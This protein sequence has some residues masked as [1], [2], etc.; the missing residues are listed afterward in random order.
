MNY[1]VGWDKQA[2]DF[3]QKIE[4]QDAQRIIKKVTS[5]TDNPKRY[6]KGLSNIDAHKLRVGNYRIL[7]DISDTEQLIN[8]LFIGHRKNIYK[9][10]KGEY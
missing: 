2:K 7:L 5:I 10:F 9:T 4:K 3:L 8:V 1:E 6:V